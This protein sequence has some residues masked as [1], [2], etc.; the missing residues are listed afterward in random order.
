M[1]APDFTTSIL[2]DQ[3]P[4]EAFKAIGNFRGWW[5]E[6][7]EGETDKLGEEFFYHYKDI[8]LC[9]LKLIEQTPH[10]RLVYQVLDNE[11]SFTEDK[12]EWINTELV[13]DIRA[14]GKQTKITFMHRGLVPQY[15]CFKVCEEAWTNYI[16]NSL[17]LLI[18]TGKGAPNPKEGEGYNAELAEKWK[19]NT[20]DADK[21]SFER[22][23]LTNR[24]AHEVF[25]T[26]INV[27]SWWSGLYSEEIEGTSN[28]LNDEFTF[29]AGGGAHYSKQ[30]LVEVIPNEK[31]VWQV[32]D[33]N[34][35]F[36]QNPHEWIGTKLCFDICEQGDKTQ[37]RFT[38]LG[39]E[40]NM[41]CYKRCST[42]W[43]QYLQ[44][45]LSPFTSKVEE[46]VV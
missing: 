11:F 46:P 13:F 36:L 29:R 8:H 40:P 30:K 43:S 17:R 41:E 35:S 38:H 5:S 27:R 39:L 18:T 28:M 45:F 9:K 20:M 33:S 3:T 34:L 32:T 37:V 6:D 21:K 23:F 1:T 7:I 25:D 16:T 22:S 19:L 24:S 26:I 4:E 2:V 42:A 14:E 31:V 10:S 44:K 15:E 12:T